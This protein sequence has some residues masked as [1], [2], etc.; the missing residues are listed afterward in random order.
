[1]LA[2]GERSEPY[3]W[4]LRLAMNQRITKP[5]IKKNGR[6]E[7]TSFNE[8]FQHIF[9][10]LQKSEANSTLVMS[11]GSY[12]NETLY[13]LQKLARTILNTN[14]L[15]SFDYYRRGTDFF[16]DKNDIL[17]FAEMFQSDKF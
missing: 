7:E 9:Q 5:Y 16:A 4:I 6:L 11:S 12:S 15:G 17:P 13:L 1:M 10:K 3:E 2:Y 8:A 14:A